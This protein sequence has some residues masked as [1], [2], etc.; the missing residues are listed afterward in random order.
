[1][2]ATPV[3]PSNAEQLRAWGGDLGDYWAANADRFDEA[4]AGYAGHFFDAMAI[5]TTDRVLDIGCGTGQS[6]REAARRA[7]SGWALGVDLSRQMIE[8]AG[9]RAAD[10]GVPNAH[11]E[12][13]D[14]QVHPFGAGDFDLAIS[15]AGATFF[16]DPEAAFDN[17]AR[18]IRPGGRL[19]L[20]VWQPA[21]HN[22]WITA[23]STA[24]AVG[25]APQQPAPGAPGPFSLGDPDRVRSLLTGAGYVDL[26]LEDRSEPMYFGRNTDDAF[27]F[28][29]GLTGSTLDGLSPPE[30]ARALDALRA[31]IDTHRGDQGVRYDS[32]TWLVT[33]ARP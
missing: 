31:S 15:R 9:R 24:L 10:E 32:A 23:F 16:A 2:Q 27:R 30:R 18:A 21:Q 33:A 1:M 8:L 7:R 29:I 3:D 19:V 13:G 20:L 22:E 14:A 28:V 5:E 26:R 11:F 4:V 25:R 12:H 6:T 17:I